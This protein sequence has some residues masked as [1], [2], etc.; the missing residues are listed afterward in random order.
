MESEVNM[1][2]IIKQEFK[3]TEGN[4][5]LIKDCIVILKIHNIYIVEVIRRYIGWCDH[6]LDYRSRKEFDD[7]DKAN[8]YFNKILRNGWYAE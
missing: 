4:D 6:G 2:Q 5:C 8:S 1:L 7:V 3:T